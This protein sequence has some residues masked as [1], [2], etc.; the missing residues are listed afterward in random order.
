MDSPNYKI[1]IQ[2][3]AACGLYCGTCPGFLKGKCPGCK[4]NEKAGWC[5]IRTCNA[6]QGY[7]S[8]G[9]C[10]EYAGRTRECKKLNNFMGKVFGLIFGSD[11]FGCI[12]RIRKV[13][14]EQFAREMAESGLRNRP[15]GHPKNKRK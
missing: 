7:I 1:D 4:G 14:N 6:E 9:E 12:E 13:G 2:L 15:V 8:C 5:K 3:I 11:R 10:A